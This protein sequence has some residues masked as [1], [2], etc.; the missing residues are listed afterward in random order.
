LTFRALY[1][2]EIDTII[3]IRT[4]DE[5]VKEIIKHPKTGAEILKDLDFLGP[6]LEYV[7]CHHERPDGKGYPAALQ[8]MRFL[9]GQKY[10]RLRIAMTP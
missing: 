3:S 6:A 5:I 1:R 7:Y 8:R 2:V 9:W 10:L 4:S